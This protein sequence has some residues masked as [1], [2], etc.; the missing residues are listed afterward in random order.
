MRG[1]HD[2]CQ[3]CHQ[4]RLSVEG[5]QVNDIMTVNRGKLLHLSDGCTYL[6]WFQIQSVPFTKIVDG[7]I[8]GSFIVMLLDNIFIYHT[9]LEHLCANK[10]QCEFQNTLC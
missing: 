9:C 2:L 6:M 10:Q 7:F 5:F 4:R 1:F 3:F 8:M